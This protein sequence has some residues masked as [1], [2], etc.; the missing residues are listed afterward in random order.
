MDNTKPF[1]EILRNNAREY[2]KKRECDSK[3]EIYLE[4]LNVLKESLERA[5]KHGCCHMYVDF[6]FGKLKFYSNLNGVNTY[7]KNSDDIDEYNNS[8][9]E[10]I[11]FSAT[12]YPEYKNIGTFITDISPFF[13]KDKMTLSVCS[14]NFYKIEW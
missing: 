10:Y 3:K 8:I 6:E 7:W 2:N 14:Y 1:G 11:L 12:R 4:L 9:H 13:K 5:S